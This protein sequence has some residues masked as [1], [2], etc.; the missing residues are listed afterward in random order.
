METLQDLPMVGG[1]LAVDF[2]NTTSNRAGDAPSEH[3]HSYADLVAWCVRAELFGTTE[4]TRLRTEAERRPADA[5]RALARALELREAVYRIFLAA[6]P[7]HSA[8]AADVGVLNGVLAQCMARRTLR[9][10]ECGMCWTWAGEADELDWILWPIA[11]SAAE[12]LT[13]SDAALLKQ[14]GGPTCDWLFVDE[15]RNHSRRWCD[16]RDCGNRA[17]ARRHYHRKTGKGV[18]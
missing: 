11:Y 9:T 12:L 6:A 3:L 14:C 7:G 18:A 15:S 1:R 5:Q 4:A 8:A 10:A 17:K 13:S 2:V 16:M